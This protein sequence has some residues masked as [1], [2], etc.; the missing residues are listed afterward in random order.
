MF[1]S[2]IAAS[3][4]LSLSAGAAV[5]GPYINVEANAAYPVGEY[6][7]AVTDFH[8]GLEGTAR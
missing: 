1:K 4:A 5:A 7:G 3:A 2:L 8:L 6:I